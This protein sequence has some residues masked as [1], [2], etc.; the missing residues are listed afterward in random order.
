MIKSPDKLP[1]VFSGNMRTSCARK[2]EFN[3]LS[4]I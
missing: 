2:P 4:P 1:L 3:K